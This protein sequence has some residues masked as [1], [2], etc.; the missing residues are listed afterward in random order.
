[1]N[2]ETRVLKQW[3]QITAIYRGRHQPVKGVGCQ[4]R[5]QQ[6]TD[7]QETQNSNH[8]RRKRVR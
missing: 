2:C 1:M 4:Q 6:E 5:E 8:T 3:V 7:R